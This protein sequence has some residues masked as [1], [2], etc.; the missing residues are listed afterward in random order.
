MSLYKDSI[1]T[2]PWLPW[3]VRNRLEQ[4]SEVKLREQWPSFYRWLH[5]GQWRNIVQPITTGPSHH[6]FGYYDKSPWNL[7][8]NLLLAHEAT[9]NDRPPSATD[10]VTIGVIKLEENN[11]FK[12]LGESYAWNWQQG[13]MLQWH[14]DDPEHLILHNDRRGDRLIGVVRNIQGDEV[15]IYDRPIYAVTPD[16]R[17]ALSLNFA[18]LHEHRPGYGYAGVHDPWVNEAHPSEDGIYLMNLHSGTSKLLISLD[19][20][21]N[22]EPAQAMQSVYHW[23]NHIQVSPGGTRFAFFHLWRVSQDRWGVRLY[24]S[25]LDGSVL[26]CLLDT[27]MASHYDWM[28]DQKLLVWAKHPDAGARFLL[29]DVD[30]KSREIIGEGVLTEDGHCSFSPNRQWILNDTYPDCY[31]LRTLMLFRMSDGKRMDLAR[32]YSPKA[33]WWGETRCDLHPRWNREGTQVCVDSVHSGERQM[34]VVDLAGLQ[35]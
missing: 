2:S 11:S 22:K 10:A 29:C 18:R 14:P 19:Q 4:W 8:G 20:L 25:N 7:S 16:G 3:R 23:I 28:D 6:F 26:E 9:F 1:L 34:Y 12:P 24:T 30:N 21:A 15:R 27:G 31:D 33:K 32:L 17:Y 35:E 13:S 5:F